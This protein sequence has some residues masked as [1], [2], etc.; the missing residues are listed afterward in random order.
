[1][2]KYVKWYTD[3]EKLRKIRNAQRKRYYDKTAKYEWRKWT[4]KEDDEV[5]EHAIT[6]TELSNKIHRSVR[7]I[8]ARRYNLKKR[9]KEEN[10][11]ENQ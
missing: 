5:L 1:M 2:P 7:A 10:E 3:K 11:K 4:S 6:D 9:M 8:Q